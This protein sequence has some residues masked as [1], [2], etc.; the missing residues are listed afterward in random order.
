MP[1]HDVT[2][3]EIY[4]ALGILE[5]KIDAMNQALLQKHADISTAFTRID[6]LARTVWIGV[7][8]AVACSVVMPLLVTASS[9][10]LHFQHQVEATQ[11]ERKP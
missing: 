9:P 2:H 7:G 11:D 1:E 4:R 3:G 5:G 8:I 10:R 6:N